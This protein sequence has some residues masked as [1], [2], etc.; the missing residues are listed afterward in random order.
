MGN[1]YRV[2]ITEWDEPHEPKTGSRPI[3]LRIG[4]GCKKFLKKKN[5]R[6]IF[7]IYSFTKTFISL[8]LFFFMINFQGKLATTT[9]IIVPLHFFHSN[10]S[11][12]CIKQKKTIKKT[13]HL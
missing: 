10:L 5:P 13:K 12:I 8:P 9:N 1:T 2:N 6:Y 4:L 11:R 3:K 7:Y